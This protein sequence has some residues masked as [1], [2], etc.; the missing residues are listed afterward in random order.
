MVIAILSILTVI[1]AALIG[2]IFVSALL[3]LEEV[4]SH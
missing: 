2:G 1:T 3:E 4:E